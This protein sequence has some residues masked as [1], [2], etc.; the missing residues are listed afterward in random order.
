MEPMDSMLGGPLREIKLCIQR[1]RHAQVFIDGQSQ[2]HLPLGLMILFGVGPEWNHPSP[3][4]LT[5]TQ[6]LTKLSQKIA[7]LR[8]FEDESGKMNWD[9]VQAGGGIYCVS[10]FTLFADL[11][12]GN[13]PS[14][15][16]ACPPSLALMIYELFLE[17]LKIELPNTTVFQGHFAAHMELQMTNQ[18]PVTLMTQWNGEGFT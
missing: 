17:K 3:L 14:F 2:G 4:T 18:G 1:V 13:R 7:K 9:V 11:K 16:G 15:S 5:W 8:I 6:S 10:Q 12:K